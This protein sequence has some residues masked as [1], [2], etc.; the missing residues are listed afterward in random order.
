MELPSRGSHLGRSRMGKGT[1][2]TW[3][4]SVECHAQLA[5]VVAGRP[6]PSPGSS[7]SLLPTPD[8]E[9]WTVRARDLIAAL[10]LAADLG[11]QER[12]TAALGWLRHD[13]LGSPGD[14]LRGHDMAGRVAKSVWASPTERENE[15]IHR[16][17]CDAIQALDSFP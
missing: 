16:V 7:A 12:V 9:Y 1:T 6:W 8:G 11:G 2:A 5:V 15:M 14:L 4:R 17:A 3:Y 10:F 13:D